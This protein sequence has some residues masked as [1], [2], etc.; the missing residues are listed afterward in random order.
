MTPDRVTTDDTVYEQYPG[1]VNP[2]QYPRPS[3]GIDVQ[4]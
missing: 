4:S 2:L 3:Y 1:D